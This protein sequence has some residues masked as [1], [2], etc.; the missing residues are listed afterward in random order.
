METLANEIR[1]IIRD[2][3]IADAKKS[4]KYIELYLGMAILTNVILQ[5]MAA[6]IPDSQSNIHNVVYEVQN[7]LRIRAKTLFKFLYESKIGSNVV[8]YFDPDKYKLTDALMLPGSRVVSV[9]RK[10]FRRHQAMILDP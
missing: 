2:N 3:D 9:S 5:Q 6:L 1:N 8:P 10:V 4:L 7:S